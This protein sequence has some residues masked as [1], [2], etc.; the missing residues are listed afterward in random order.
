[1][2]LQLITESLRLQRSQTTFRLDDKVPMA[3]PQLTP[4]KDLA[5]AIQPDS[6]YEQNVWALACILFDDQDSVA[7]G[8][9]VT[10]KDEYDHRTRKDRLIEFWERLCEA[11]ARKAVD[12]APNAEERA[13]AY[14]SANK[15]V[16][17]CD[18][19]VHGKDF[20][21]A[22]LI[23]QIGGDTEM[24]EDMLAQIDSW[25]ELNVL[26]E[27]TEPI[28]ALYSLLA[29]NTCICE[30]RKGSLEDRA[31]TFVI[32][33]RFHLD[34]KRAFALR[35]CF[36]I[37]AQDPIE[38]AVKKYE[39]DL[40][41][42]EGRK[43]VPWYVESQVKIP[44]EDPHPSQRE[45]IL[46]G[47]LKLYAAS[48]NSLPAQSLANTIMPE[49]IGLNPTDV[50]LSFQLYYALALR[51]PSTSSSAAGDALAKSY[52][53]QL[54]SAGEWLWALFA[55]LHL[56]DAAERR[57][58]IQ[59]IL[60][61][62][63]QDIRADPPDDN[64]QTLTRDMKIPEKWIWQ[65]KALYARSVTQDH[66]REVEYLVKAS[67]WDEAHEVLRNT[68]GPTCVIGEEWDT[69]QGLIDS[70]KAGKENLNDWGIGGQV[71]ADYLDLMKGIGER[72]KIDALNRLL[73]ALPYMTRGKPRSED[74]KVSNFNQ[75]VAVQEIRG[76]VG[77]EVL[78][79]QEKVGS[80]GL[81][82]N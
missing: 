60:A 76:V 6:E 9:P 7:F 65:A 24:R 16:D 15:V 39:D 70:F 80:Y 13:I 71:Y 52:T 21:L 23:A 36:A 58:A 69:L 44:W 2:K 46:W 29:G 56:S 66:V 17:A 75:M 38:T 27:M 8:I 45:D 22:I 11:S 63:A 51:L 53:T 4:F 10:Q 34:W 26:S 3:H 19:L 64:F 73:E 37:L 77:R 1:M 48:K 79:M 30:G 62:H 41:T 35:L 18:A 33:E 14:L 50:R 49:N 74:G 57:K 55:S 32:S 12:E 81:R 25:R 28:R 42:D 20:R 59:T 72:E 82:M 40:K 68:V 78:A 67:D 61:H 31:R 43:P 47:L 54:D 5:S